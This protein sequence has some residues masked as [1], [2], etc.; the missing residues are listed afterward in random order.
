[1]N[2]ADGGF[3]ADCVAVPMQSKAVII[4]TTSGFD[5][6]NSFPFIIKLVFVVRQGVQT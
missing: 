4:K 2:V 5:F 3:G 6:I 1:V